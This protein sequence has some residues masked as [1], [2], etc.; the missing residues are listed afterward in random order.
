M[1]NS[2]SGDPDLTDCTEA[3]RA[4]A[5][6]LKAYFNTAFNVIMASGD[7][8]SFAIEGE[9]ASKWRDR[10]FRDEPRSLTSA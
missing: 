6:I 4:A 1:I 7:E 8:Q 10:I 5:M 9:P 3:E 2:R